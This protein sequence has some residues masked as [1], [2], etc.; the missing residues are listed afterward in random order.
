M[1]RS[2]SSCAVLIGAQIIGASQAAAE[3][4]T[5]PATA[6]ITI[7]DPAP[8]PPPPA[9]PV[10][11]PPPGSPPPEGPPT[12]PR[13]PSR[14]HLD[15]HGYFRARYVNIRRVPVGR[16]DSTGTLASEVHTG[17]DDAS[18]GHFIYSRLRLDP[19][20]R[21]G[22]NPM[23]GEL[24]KV[25]LNA[26]IDV[27]DNVMWGDNARQTGV[28]LFAENPSTTGIDGDERPFLLVRRLWMEV[29][30][31]VGVVRLGRQASHG[32]LGIL[33]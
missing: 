1:L 21:W 29:T 3:E 10:T 26:Q 4:P 33:F 14:L 17:R 28:P 8:E 12:P 16:L 11:L 5:P 9:P 19:T 32:G 31:P 15:M 13:A 23:A 18:N 22:G 27:L 25:A 20:L 2:I 30:L 7:R 24:P 6:T